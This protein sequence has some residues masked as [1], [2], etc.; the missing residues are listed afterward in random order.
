M[1]HPL[2]ARIDADQV[3]R[4]LWLEAGSATLAEAAVYAGFRFLLIDN[5]HGPASIET[6]LAMVRAIEAAGGHAMARVAWN[7]PML[8]KRHLEIGV[9]T[10][11]VPNVETADEARAAVAA[12]RYPPVGRR[13]YAAEIRAA[14]YGLDAG[15]A[16]RA[17]DDIFL[18]LQIE[19]VV[20][21]ANAAAIAALDGIDML[22][23]G[24]Y[25]L[26]GSLGV[27]GETGDDL[28]T[29]ALAQV[30]A[31]AKAAGRPLGSVPRAGRSA[32]DLAA[33]G[34]RLIIDHSDLGHAVAALRADVEATPE[35][36]LGA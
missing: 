11:L 33:D 29:A 2:R 28:V 14:R 7:D 26:S 12:C 32:A 10:L 15:Y 8:L 23:P 3:T 25:D 16:A 4:A 36:W 21:V 6:T 20:G 5:E 9:R 34:Y 17:N 24:P 19:S 22:F 18:M 35:P 1:T 27:P 30:E 31:A 13:G